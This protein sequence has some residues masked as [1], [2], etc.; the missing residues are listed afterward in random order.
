MT[1]ET[2]NVDTRRDTRPGVYAGEW[3]PSRRS[4]GKWDDEIERHDGGPDDADT[5][6]AETGVPGRYGRAGRGRRVLQGWSADRS[7]RKPA[8]QGN[9]G[10]RPP[11]ARPRSA[12]EEAECGKSGVGMICWA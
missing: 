7:E 1:A 2:I 4:Y 8:M 10:I 12:L 6:V 5:Y 11:A 3:H 9:F